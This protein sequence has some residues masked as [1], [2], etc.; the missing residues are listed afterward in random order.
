MVSG[1]NLAV[2]DRRGE[3]AGSQPVSDRCRRVGYFAVKKGLL[4]RTADTSMRS[5][6]SF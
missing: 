5:T 6:A 2:A 1:A 4:R 3:T